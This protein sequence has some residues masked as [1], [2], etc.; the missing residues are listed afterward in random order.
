MKVFQTAHTFAPF[1]N[2]L[3]QKYHISERDY[4]FAELQSIVIDEGFNAVH[5]LLPIL[6]GDKENGF[7]TL[8]NYE[9]MQRRWAKENGCRET[10][11]KAIQR[12]QIE[13]FDP[14]VFYT[15][16]PI[17]YTPEEIRA[18]PEKMIKL[19]WFASP[20]KNNIDFSAYHAR[21]TNLPTD[22]GTENGFRSLFFQL[23]D[24]PVFHQFSDQTHRPI[25]VLFFGQYMKDHFDKRNGYIHELIRLQEKHGF[26]LMLALMTNYEYEHLLP[27]KLPYALHEKFK[28]LRFPP[29]QV[30]EKAH[31]PL[32][33]TSM[34]RTIGQAKIVFNCHVDIA[35]E[36]R[37]NMRIFEA[38]GCGAHMLSDEGI[39]PDGLIPGTHFT[40][41]KNIG[42]L[43]AK[44]VHLL[45]NDKER[46][47]IAQEGTTAIRALYSKEQQWQQ[48]QKIAASFS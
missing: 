31:A 35:G 9:P 27:F 42:D 3:E 4:S 38:L 14:D 5:H 45:A 29:K 23:S 22:V 15:L 20:E 30:A 48:F 17:Q 11:L 39:Y 25:D 12:A 8:W 2:Y 40:T 7:Y 13:A 6:N 36:H 24:A 33:G 19:S 21:L 46:T 28:V 1:T 47:T 41:Y 26:N 32:F 10:D 34:L 43:E 44:I 37:V 18:L 16:S